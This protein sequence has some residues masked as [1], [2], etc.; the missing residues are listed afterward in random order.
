MNKVPFF[1]VFF[2]ILVFVSIKYYNLKEYTIYDAKIIG[3]EKVNVTV[4]TSTHGGTTTYTKLTPCVEYYKNSKDTIRY[5]D[6][7]RVLYSSFYKNEKVKVL[8]DKNNQYNTTIFCLS[9]YWLEVSEIIMLALF[10][11]VF[12]G[13]YKV[14]LKKK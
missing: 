12:I 10:A 3:F 7:K 11:T 13:F 9:Y 14:F 2:L 1:I 5:Y 8:E 6:G 4:A